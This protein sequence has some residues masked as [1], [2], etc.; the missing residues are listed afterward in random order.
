MCFDILEKQQ[1][2]TYRSDEHDL[3]MS[4]RNGNYL[5]ENEQ[6]LPEFFDF[7]DT[8]EKRLDYDS[9]NTELPEKPDYEKIYDL[10]ESIN[11]Q[12]C[13]FSMPKE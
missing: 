7:L 13:T 11:W 9:K 2:I 12:V 10:V 4:I 1:I 8:L 6:P 3:F 5:D